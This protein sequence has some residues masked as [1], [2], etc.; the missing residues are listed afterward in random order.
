MWLWMRKSDVLEFKGFMGALE[1]QDLPG[2][3]NQVVTRWFVRVNAADIPRLEPGLRVHPL[4]S[5]ELCP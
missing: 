4:R 3:I 5:P 2:Q 1:P